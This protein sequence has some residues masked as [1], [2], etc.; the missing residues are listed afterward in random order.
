MLSPVRLPDSPGPRVPGCPAR[1]LTAAD[2]S[3]ETRP[4]GRAVHVTSL[5]AAECARYRYLRSDRLRPPLPPTRPPTHTGV[6]EGAGGRPGECVDSPR[7]STRHA[8]LSPPVHPKQTPSPPHTAAPAAGQRCHRV[9]RSRLSVFGCAH[10]AWT[11]WTLSWCVRRHRGNPLG[12]GR[13]GIR[14]RPPP[15]AASQWPL[16]PLPPAANGGARAAPPLQLG[17][18]G[19]GGV[20]ARPSDT[21]LGAVATAI[22][23]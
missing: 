3:H 5:S 13:G 7:T 21:R 4:S 1:R 22:D 17:C 8:P 2:G 23:R 10:T 11:V 12:I 16:N 18:A 6:V 9:Q 14:H 19:R 15:P 20:A